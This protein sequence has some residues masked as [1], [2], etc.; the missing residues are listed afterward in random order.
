MEKAYSF[1]L[2]LSVLSEL[3]R[4]VHPHG[5][6]YK[7]DGFLHDMKA[8]LQYFPNTSV[9]HLHTKAHLKTFHHG[10]D[11]QGYKK[12]SLVNFVSTVGLSMRSSSLP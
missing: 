12:R 5:T 6:T 11:E 2:L 8:T 4:R 10:N 1:L 3:E 9:L 7:E